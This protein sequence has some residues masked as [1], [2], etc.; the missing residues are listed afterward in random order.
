MKRLLAA[1]RRVLTIGALAAVAVVVAAGYGYAAVTADNQ[2]YTGCLDMSG[3]ITN[4]KIGST[5]LKPCQKSS[6][7]ISWSQTGPAGTNGTNGSNG[8]SVTS[9]TEPAGANCAGSSKFTPDGIVTYAC[10]GTKGDKGDSGDNDS[11]NL[12]ALQ[13]SPCTC[14]KTTPPASTCVSTRPASSAF[15]A[16]TRSKPR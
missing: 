8:V 4:V 12:A 7:Q 10:N 1:P 5:P 16:G 15:P 13:G 6:Q 9:A 11:A 3:V 14:T 2:T